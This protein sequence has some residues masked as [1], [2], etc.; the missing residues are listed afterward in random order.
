ME[1][2]SDRR[3][4]GL[5]GFVLC[6][7]VTCCWSASRETERAAA[8]PVTTLVHFLWS[9][10]ARGG[11]V[12]FC[13]FPLSFSIEFRRH[14]PRGQPKRNFRR[15]EFLPVCHKRNKI[16]ISFYQQCLCDMALCL[17]LQSISAKIE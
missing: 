15:F 8:H 14:S 6:S 13:L 12:E 17:K 3:R 11:V 4:G 9:I 2:K 5:S 7:V 10:V 1:H 16:T